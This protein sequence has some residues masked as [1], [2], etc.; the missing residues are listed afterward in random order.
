M[1]HAIRFHPE[2]QI[3]RRGWNVLEVISAIVVGSAIQIRRADLLHRL[4]VASRSVLA[5]AKHQMF[6]QV[7]KAGLAGLLVLRPDV[8]P[9]VDRHDRSLVILMDDYRQS[10]VQYEPRVG[11]INLFGLATPSIEKASPVPTSVSLFV[12]N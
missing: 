4:D 10:V 1:S 3:D 5:A 8:V 6:E 11:N 7:R 12:P 2:R 9:H